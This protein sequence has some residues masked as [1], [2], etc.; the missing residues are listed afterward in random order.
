MHDLALNSLR[1]PAARF[2]AILLLL[3]LLSLPAA[4]AAAVTAPILDLN[5][6]A[7]GIH[8]A[9]TFSE[10]EGAESIVNATGLF[11]SYSD[12]ATLTTA[13]ARLLARPDGALESLSADPGA[14]G[15]TVKYQKGE[16]TVEGVA[17]LAAYEQV[18]R[19]LTYN[20][21]SQSPDISDRVVEVTV[22]NGGLTSAPATTTIYINAVND[23]PVLDNSGDM[24]LPPINEDDA[25]SGGNSVKGIIESAEQ[26][27]QDRI[28]D[29]D[30]G[31]L[32]GMAVIEA[33][34]S[35][36]VWQYSLTA[37][38]N[39]LPFPAVS[40]T[41][42]ILLN[43]T[44]R[45]RFVPALGYSGSA[46]FVFRAWDQ[47]AGRE[48]GQTGVDV[49]IN[50]GTTPFSAQS[51]T[52]VIEV[53]A[54]DDLPLI[55]LNGSEEG[56]AFSP[57][58]T[59]G[60]AAVAIADSDATISDADHTTLASL[61]AT[62]TNRP[63][64]TAERLAA[65]TDG[66]AITAA[67][68][69]PAT[70]RL[71]L[72]GPDSVAAFQQ[73]L[74]TIVY[75]N[76]A[77]NPNATA[78][79][80]EVV[81]YDGIALGNTAISTIR[82]NAANTAPVLNAPSPLSL[83]DVAE[84]TLQPA[85]KAISAI[86]AAAGNPISDADSG[87]VEG[88][89]LIATDNSRGQW[90]FALVNPPAGPADWQ[91]VGV[92]SPT[93]ALLLPDTAWLRFVPAANTVGA[94]G[95]LTLRAWDQT[96]GAAGQRADA[97][98][99]GGSTAFSAATGTI[100]ATV[101]PVNDPPQL[102]GLPAAALQYVED[103]TLRL[104]PGVVVADIDSTSLASARVRLTNPI[105]GDAEWLMVTTG[106]TGITAT[107]EDGV[108]QLTGAASAAAYQQVLRT[109]SYRNTSQDPD[110]ADRL[111]EVT[112]ADAQSSSS[113]A[114]LTVQLQPVNDPPDLDLNGAGAGFDN[115]AVFYI[116]RTPVALA[117]DLVAADRDNTTLR[118]ATIR[119]TNPLNPQAER[120]TADTS[121]AANIALDYD[122]A[123]DV[124]TLTGVDSVANYQLV[125]R[126]V[127]YD[128][129]LPQPNA[130]DRVIE[131]TLD[132][133]VNVSTPR[134]T[135]LHLLPAPTARML[136]PLVSRRA[137]EPNDACAEAYPL[138]LNRHESFLPDDAMD[139]FTF[140][141]TAAADVTVELRGFSPGRGQLNVASGQGCQQLQ[142]IGTSGEPTPDKIVSLGR[143]EAG[144][145]YIR[146]IADGPLSQTAGYDLFVRATPT[147]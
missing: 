23:A 119:I 77:T 105:D 49:S 42:A 47:S 26:G 20:N 97:S 41:A 75:R 120:L 143:Q 76:D 117:A 116:N 131:F 137:E 87:A 104:M 56:T 68:Y 12:G 88:I 109:V 52:V 57:Q 62:L 33:V 8:A 1:R 141:L 21:T 110:P 85:G 30:A 130:D 90:Q 138:V 5:G 144:R 101:T 63:D 142:L 124:L 111:F 39:W 82:I 94:S 58:F 128:N 31:A 17:S 145:Y 146:I 55:D 74:R 60:G 73:V 43:E 50:G 15:L 132:D 11:I 125:L 70:G 98:Q 139:W 6:E 93:A 80:V 44:S 37:G 112:A 106:A 122:E 114:L 2:P 46:S 27:G 134:Q 95:G 140:D 67:P 99:T 29:V 133:G 51:E 113:A 129:V 135:L 25:N 64:G 126:T 7:D 91:P 13:K 72:S 108:L 89:A 107:Y 102:S 32:E 10:D 121:V 136:L 127:T 79:V 38:A 66:T 84:D 16:L 53:L 69:D 100:V 115:E 96:S 34:S 18:L 9:A 35:N 59:G 40:N 61:T 19:S 24:T 118:R 123:T 4:P 45:I 54:V 103:A 78:R 86:L 28:T 92:V 3:L 22:S 48:N 81:A 71:V 14:T 83:G 36:G 65:T 147:P